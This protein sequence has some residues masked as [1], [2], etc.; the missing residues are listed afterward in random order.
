MTTNKE[1]LEL[2]EKATPGP[3]W[4]DDNGGIRFGRV[5]VAV[6]PFSAPKEVEIANARFIAAARTELPRL[7]RENEALR[8]QLAAAL[9][10]RAD[11]VF[12]ESTPHLIGGE[13]EVEKES[14]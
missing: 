6:I 8:E 7:V 3:W 12:R 4:E 1:L 10:P 5:P 14:P 2:C 13:L 9:K 11:F